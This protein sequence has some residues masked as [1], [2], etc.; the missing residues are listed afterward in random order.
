MDLA[1]VSRSLIAHLPREEDGA[2]QERYYRQVVEYAR[3]VWGYVYESRT[4]RQ[5][6]GRR[7]EAGP[8]LHPLLSAQRSTSQRQPSSIALLP[9]YAYLTTIQ[10]YR[11]T[12]ITSTRPRFSMTRQVQY[13]YPKWQRV[14]RELQP[15]TCASLWQ[16]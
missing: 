12:E 11:S 15:S 14:Y 5:K 4:R 2:L 13:P 10:L 16:C 1:P 6:S 8:S 9:L 3:R 7:D